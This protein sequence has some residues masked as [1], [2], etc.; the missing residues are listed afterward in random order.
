MRSIAELGEF[1]LIA[2][3][4]RAASSGGSSVRLGIGDD[5]ALLRVR[6]GQDTVVSTDAST[7]GVHFRWRNAHPR[8]V[9]RRAMLAALSDLAAMGARPLAFTWALAAP[10]SLPLSRFDALLAGL[11]A[12]SQP[13]HCALVGGNVSRA[14]RTSLTLTVLGSVPGGR[15]LRRKARAGDRILLTGVLGASALDRLRAERSGG[16]IRHLPA[17]RLAAGRRL[18]RT[19]GV[20]GCIDVSDGLEADLGHLLGPELELPLEPARLPRAP[21]FERACARLGVSATEL[22]LR[23]GED[24][25]LLFSVRGNAPSA[26]TLSRRLAVPVTE[27]GRVRRG[28]SGRRA[29]GWRHF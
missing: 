27:L 18:A 25:E 5:A 29:G 23:G 13:Q 19:A 15:A 17:S 22:L 8:T 20:V 10:P 12:E 4:R 16:R 6:R 7:E 2:R 24:Y 14:V 21:G 9:G 1:G 11:L 26:S 28:S 3:T